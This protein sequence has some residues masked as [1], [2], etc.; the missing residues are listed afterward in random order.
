MVA[1]VKTR[2]ASKEDDAEK[3]PVILKYVLR[4]FREEPPEE[5]DYKSPVIPGAD[6]VTW[7]QGKGTLF[8][9][10]LSEVRCRCYMLYL[11]DAE[12]PPEEDAQEL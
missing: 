12:E 4:A 2:K 7:W 10:I 8:L 11:E 5:D 1:A 3:P 6:H 9:L